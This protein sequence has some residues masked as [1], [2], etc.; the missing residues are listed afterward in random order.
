MRLTDLELKTIKETIKVFCSKAK[1]YLYGSRVIDNAKGG[2][3][4]LLVISDLLTFSHK[5]SILAELKKKLG[6]QKIDLILSTTS[7]SN[8]DAFIQEILK[9]SVEI[10]Q[11]E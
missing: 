8:D 7:K 5:I 10:E 3:I 4:D 6:E 11:S 9:N 2:D 1:I